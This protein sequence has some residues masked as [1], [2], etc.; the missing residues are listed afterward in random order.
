METEQKQSVFFDII[1]EKL[2]SIIISKF[3]L[4]EATNKNTIEMWVGV[5]D[6]QK[7]E[8][9]RYCKSIF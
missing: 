8:V 9:Q 6:S 4:S 1:A 2:F 3:F 7:E 5:N